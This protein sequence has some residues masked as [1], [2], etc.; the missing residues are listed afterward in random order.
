MRVADAV[1]VTSIVRRLKVGEKF[2]DAD[3]DWIVTRSPEVLNDD[4]VIVYVL[5]YPTKEGQRSRGYIYDYNAQV[6]ML[7]K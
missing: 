3:G 4:A 6:K 2:T 7:R 5:P 1:R